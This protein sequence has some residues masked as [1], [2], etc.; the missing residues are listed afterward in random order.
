MKNHEV[1]I[2]R[3]F[4]LAQKSV[5]LGDHPFGALITDSDGEIIAEGINSGKNDVTGHAEVNAIKSMIA[6]DLDKKDYS[7]Y[8][9]YTN[10]EP[11]AMCS[12]VIRD[13][14]IGRVV[15]SARSPFWG[16]LSR[17]D[18]LKS[19]DIRPEFTTFGSSAVPEVI[20]GV[21]SDVANK[22]FSDLGWLMHIEK[23]D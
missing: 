5:E 2:K 11:C 6:V 12:F 19:E 21:L 1:Y 13:V 18:I 9:L 16:G 15:F 4:E 20:P 22:N 10:F 7:G 8:T 23:N 14:G 3:C 17:W